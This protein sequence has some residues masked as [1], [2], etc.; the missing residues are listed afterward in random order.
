MYYEALKWLKPNMVVPGNTVLTVRNSAHNL[1]R[2]T[3]EII[4]S[5][6]LL[7]PLAMAGAVVDANAQWV[8]MV[9]GTAV[10]QPSFFGSKEVVECVSQAYLLEGLTYSWESTDS[11]KIVQAF[12]MVLDKLQIETV[13]VTDPS[14]SVPLTGSNNDSMVSIT[15]MNPFIG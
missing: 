11:D 2:Q 4:R 5:N 8:K 13:T 3:E 10:N 15:E 7:T 9:E 1:L 12:Q 6:R 14:V